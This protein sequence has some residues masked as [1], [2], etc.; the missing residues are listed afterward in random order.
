[1]ASPA[2]RNNTKANRLLTS[3]DEFPRHAVVSLQ[4]ASL[5]ITRR[6]ASVISVAQGMWTCSGLS[7]RSLGH[8][9]SEC[10]I[11][12][13]MHG[14]CPLSACPGRFQSYPGGPVC[15]ASCLC[16]GG[17]CTQYG[18]GNTSNAT[19]RSSQP[20][21]PLAGE[22]SCSNYGPKV[23]PFPYARQNFSSATPSVA[24]LFFNHRAP[25]MQ[26]D[27]GRLIGLAI[28]LV[29]QKKCFVISFLV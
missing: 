8:P 10:P 24:I 6:Q 7:G 17:Q 13:R 9:D 12:R 26:H 28:P 23:F 25:P 15:G 4:P 19:P 3:T 16:I 2:P 27:R 5:H 18:G 22:I 29:T 11:P 20:R 14:S 1:M 21:I